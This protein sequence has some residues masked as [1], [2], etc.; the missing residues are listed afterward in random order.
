[1]LWV[2]PPITDPLK[3]RAG[4]ET[5]IVAPGPA[6]RSADWAEALPAKREPAVNAT[7][8][9]KDF[10]MASSSRSEFLADNIRIAVFLDLKGAKEPIVLQKEIGSEGV[11]LSDLGTSYTGASRRRENWGSQISAVKRQPAGT[12]DTLVKPVISLRAGDG[13]EAVDGHVLWIIAAVVVTNGDFAVVVNRNAGE[14]LIAARSG[15]GRRRGTY[16]RREGERYA[17]VGG[18]GNLD[19]R[20]CVDPGGGY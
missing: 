6:P 14:E 15:K 8:M 9:R 18:F 19:I 20:I 11:V 7:A 2:K 5:R 1:M 10:F 4:S 3:S 12:G 17:E 16:S 13:A